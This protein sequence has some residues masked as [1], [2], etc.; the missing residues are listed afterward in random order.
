MLTWDE[1]GTESVGG[2]SV[3]LEPS[4]KWLLGM[5]AADMAEASRVNRVRG[6]RC[7]GSSCHYPCRFGHSSAVS[8]EFLYAPENFSALTNW[9]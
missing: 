5:D 6:V 3:E 7:S 1:E 9:L 8:V 4:W 2:Y